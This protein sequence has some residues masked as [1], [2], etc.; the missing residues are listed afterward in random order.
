MREIMRKA[1]L[2]FT[3]L[4]LATSSY[5]LDQVVRSGETETNAI[6]LTNDGDRAIVEEGGTLAPSTSGAKAITMSNDNQTALNQGTISTKGSSAH[7]IFNNQR[8]SAVITN[9]GSISTISN[10]SHGIFSNQGDSAV[11]TNSGSITTIG[12]TADG[13]R[14][15]GGSSDGVVITN[16]GV[17]TVTGTTAVG[18]RS[19]SSPNVHVINSGTIRSAQFRAIDLGGTNPTLTLLRGSNLQGG[20]RALSSFN[21]IIH[22]STCLQDAV[23]SVFILPISPI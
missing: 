17:I 13:I 8:A 18:I 15:S 1:S 19:D 2:L 14:N 23:M 9:S 7:G 12:N 21:L 6:D 11:I 3:L 20:V 10:F 22:S 5:A 4:S 16:S